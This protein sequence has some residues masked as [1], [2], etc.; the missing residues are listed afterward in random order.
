MRYRFFVK[1]LLLAN[2]YVF[3]VNAAAC[4][5]T[6]PLQSSGSLEGAEVRDILIFGASYVDNTFLIN[7]LSGK[8]IFKGYLK[9]QLDEPQYLVLSENQDAPQTIENSLSILRPVVETGENTFY[10][11]PFALDSLN[12][13]SPSKILFAQK[14]YSCFERKKIHSIIL[15]VSYASSMNILTKRII[16][17]LKMLID[18]F[19]WSNLKKYLDCLFL[20]LIDVPPDEVGK[21]HTFFKGAPGSAKGVFSSSIYCKLPPI[22]MSERIKMT[23]ELYK[24]FVDN[25]GLIRRIGTGEVAKLSGIILDERSLALL[26]GAV[27]DEAPQSSTED[28]RIPAT[29]SPT[30][31]ATKRNI[32]KDIG[33]NELIIKLG[34][35]RIDDGYSTYSTEIL[36]KFKL[37]LDKQLE[38]LILPAISDAVAERIV[39]AEGDEARVDDGST[40]GEGPA[41]TEAAEGAQ[42]LTEKGMDEL[43]SACRTLDQSTDI[44]SLLYAKMSDWPATPDADTDETRKFLAERVCEIIER[45]IK[46][47]KPVRAKAWYHGYMPAYLERKGKEIFGVATESAGSSGYPCTEAQLSKAA[48]SRKLDRYLHELGSKISALQVKLQYKNQAFCLTHPE[49][50]FT[51]GEKSLS[52]FITPSLRLVIESKLSSSSAPD[53]IRPLV[54]SFSYS[55]SSA[56]DTIFPLFTA[57][58]SSSALLRGDIIGDY[59]VYLNKLRNLGEGEAPKIARYFSTRSATWQRGASQDEYSSVC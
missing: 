58:P 5:E 15:N 35:R 34:R 16:C 50:P 52:I 59:W 9:D 37:K 53:T 6:L 56:P 46:A 23:R 27:A 29:G 57:Y 32:R 39:A 45:R 33:I 14:G 44:Q 30:K 13:D 2:V 41:P 54:T 28:S 7:Y 11:L 38:S 48:A 40:G 49:Y 4:T 12:A 51:V 43:V 20:I 31:R 1:V 47:K 24:R 18:P 10:T 55:S 19:D 36:K 8:T 21:L 26:D 42:E 3:C 25:Y 22:E 17:T